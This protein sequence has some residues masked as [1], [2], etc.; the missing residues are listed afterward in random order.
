MKTLT[1][2]EWDRIVTL[3]ITRSVEDDNGCWI[4][5]G[6]TDGAGR[7]C[8]MFRGKKTTLARL[9]LT[10]DGVLALDDTLCACHDCDN[11]ACVRP[12]HLCVGTQSQ[13]MQDSYDRD[14][15]PHAFAAGKW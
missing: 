15:R 4:W 3:C 14:R 10:A 5:Q 2:E 6:A 12:D 13:N 1:T 9:S 8:I 11:V 7:A